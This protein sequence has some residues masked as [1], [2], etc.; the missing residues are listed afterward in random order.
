[1]EDVYNIKRMW[2]A[3]E[4]LSMTDYC[5]EDVSQCASPRG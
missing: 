2:T 5:A 1:M 4:K 3:L